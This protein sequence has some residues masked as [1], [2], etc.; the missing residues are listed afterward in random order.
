MRRAKIVCTL[1]PASSDE[2]TLEKLVRAG[3]NVA[4]LNFS[5]GT[6]DDHRET[7]ARV[8]R[9]SERLQTPVAILQ[10]LQGPKI[11]VGTFRDGGALLVP[12]SSFQFVLDDV[13]G[14]EHRVSVS[15]TKL[16]EDVHVG[17]EIL[18]DDGLL[19]VRVVEKGPDYVTTTVVNGGILKDRK[20]MNLPDTNVSLPSLTPKDRED[21]AFGLELGVEFVALSF[22]RSSLDIHQLRCYLPEN[23]K[24][25][26]HIIAKIEK[27]QAVRNLGEIVAAS[28]GVMVA[29]GDLGVEMAAERVPVIQ[30]QAIAL[31]NA[32]GKISITATQ[33]LDSMQVNPRP[34]RAE[35][36]DVANAI[37]DGTDAVML[38]GETASGL[39]PVESVRMMDR[40]VREAEASSY[41]SV[42]PA[43]VHGHDSIRSFTLA[44]AKAASVAAEELNVSAIA[45]FTV[46]GGTARLIKS[47]RPR[48]DVLAF[49]PKAATYHRMAL[50][51]G[52]TPVLTDT[53]HTTDELIQLVQDEMLRMG[54]A[55]PGG[56]IIIVMGVP[57][58]V[59]TATNMIK[60][61]AIPYDS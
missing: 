33:M 42:G 25:R 22:V 10:D 52:I 53:R 40:I 34:T 24:E 49:T 4:R 57:V 55:E 1:G 6:F 56:Q 9:V 41:M 13:L 11:R 7:H 12:G 39:Y 27:P 18:L 45:C 8:R 2:E 50:Y 51:R 60:F 61:H 48:R 54:V 32:M 58:G 59:G 44:I 21:L 20:G 38:S 3:M 26:P 37:F 43:P 35:A 29:R 14:D 5:H 16:V 17:E 15:Y 23:I 47:Q 31:A 36:S 28:D 46:S 19:R 30:K